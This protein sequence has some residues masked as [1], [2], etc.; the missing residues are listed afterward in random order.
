MK[1]KTFFL[2]FIVIL[3][4]GCGTAANGIK[5]SEIEPER[6]QKQETA[7]IIVYRPSRII[8]SGDRMNII[9]NGVSKGALH[10]LGYKIIDL[11][12][13]RIVINTDTSGIDRP[14]KLVVRPGETVF[15]K[16]EFKNYVVTGAWDLI[17]VDKDTA[18]KELT[19]LRESKP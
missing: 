10:P 3:L 13:N 4:S 8:G 15:L 1:N 17:V 16:T 9:V 7:K 5:F 6:I 18:K 19:E 2:I 14:Q 12:Q 11:N